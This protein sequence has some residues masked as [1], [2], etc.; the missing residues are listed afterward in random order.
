MDFLPGFGWQHD[1][2]DFRDLLPGH[3]PVQELLKL[4]PESGAPPTE[5]DL[6]EFF[7]GVHDQHQLNSSSAYACAELF[8]YFKRRTL[9]RLE[10]MSRLFLYKNARALLCQSGNVPVDLRTTLKAMLTFGCPPERLWPD[11]VESFDREP[12]AMMY[13]FAK[14]FHSVRYVRL[15]E[16]NRD[17]SHAL[18]T[19]KAFLAAGLPVAFGFMV[20]YSISEQGD[21]PYRPAFDSFA[22][23]QA[24]VA[25][26]YNDQW[27][28]S[29]RGALLI[30]NSWGRTWGDEGY[31]WLP[32]SFVVNQLAVAFWTLISA[33]WMA[34]GKF[35]RPRLSDHE[36]IPSAHPQSSAN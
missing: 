17:G 3:R 33:D 10:R 30:R 4:A 13:S 31:A 21:I 1:P 6:R 22:G 29:R 27:L 32:Y 26:G 18:Q 7:L 35:L 15:D 25:V 20:P 28:G 19:V 5:V 8:E 14:P 36:G 16:P 23:G 12:P 11:E 24:V 9:G 34:S 2:P